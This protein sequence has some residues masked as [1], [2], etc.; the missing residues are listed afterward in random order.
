MP[1]ALERKYLNGAAD[2]RWQ[3][4][5]PQERRWRNPTIGEQ[6]RQ[7]VDESLVQRAVFERNRAL[8]GVNRNITRSPG[9]DLVDQGKNLGFNPGSV[10]YFR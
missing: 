10:T 5:V 2:R 4:G 1:Y 3:W 9:F 7:H 8:C 6:G